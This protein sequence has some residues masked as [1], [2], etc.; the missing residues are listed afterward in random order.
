MSRREVFKKMKKNDG[1]A[2]IVC[3]TIIAILLI[4]VFSLLL[5]S[6]VL[7]SSQNKNLQSDK[8]AEA[9]KTLSVALSEQMAANDAEDDLYRYVRYN[10]WQ[11]NWPYYAPGVDGHT[12]EDAFRYFSMN[13]NTD[14]SGFPSKVQVC[15]YWMLPEDGAAAVDLSH[16]EDITADIKGN[17]RLFMEVSSS[18]GSQ[19]FR[20]KNE[21]VLTVSKTVGT[22]HPVASGEGVNPM[23]NVIDTEENWIWE[24]VERE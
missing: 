17:A 8:T 3:I 24:F 16:P 22:E 14:M 10:M 7:Y 13:K 20:M 5:A 2:M 6:Y 23:N 4:F 1:V 11:A 19:N 15:I 12:E 18:A 9:T 21:F